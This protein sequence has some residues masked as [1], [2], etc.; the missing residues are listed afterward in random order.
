MLGLKL[1]YVEVI[2]HNDLNTETAGLID[3]PAREVTIARNFSHEVQRFTAAHEIAHWLWH[4]GLRKHRD[5]PCDGSDTRRLRSVEELEADFFAAKFLMPTPLVKAQFQDRV[6]RSTIDLNSVDEDVFHQFAGELIGL[7]RA[8]LQKQG[9]DWVAKK[10]ASA[11]QFAG[12]NFKSLR[13]VFGVSPSAMGI[14]LVQLELVT[15]FSLPA[16]GFLTDTR[17][18]F[19]DL[20]ADFFG[21]LT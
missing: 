16:Q 10:L 6:C 4:P 8:D 13:E 20:D 14:E 1:N 5:R 18:P 9:K 12:M 11:T 2:P 3:M 7:H 15:A 17:V 19:I 21:P